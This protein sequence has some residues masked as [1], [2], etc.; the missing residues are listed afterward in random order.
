MDQA[1]RDQ[2]LGEVNELKEV[3]RRA[4]IVK[5]RN[6]AWIQVLGTVSGNNKIRAEVKL[7]WGEWP[8]TQD[9]L[10]MVTEN[11][12]EDMRVTFLETSN[13]SVKTIV[14]RGVNKL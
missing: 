12:N 3:C 8:S 1:V 6:R 2:I 10:A 13:P 7:I 11:D 4:R 14:I 5:V 9:I